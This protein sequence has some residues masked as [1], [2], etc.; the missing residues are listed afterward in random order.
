[1]E[2]KSAYWSFEHAWVEFGD[3]EWP[4]REVV[5]IPPVKNVRSEQGQRGWGAVEIGLAVE[6]RRK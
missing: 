5:F 4:A 2:A 6:C 3:G 1:M